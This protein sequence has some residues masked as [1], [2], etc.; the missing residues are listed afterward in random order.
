MNANVAKRVLFVAHVDSHI[1]AFHIPFLKFFKDHSFIV[2]VASNGNTHFEY[3]YHKYNL[4]FQ[5]NPLSLTNYKAFKQLRKILNENKYDIIH[6]HTPT[7]GV[8]ARL[9]NRF[10]KHYTTTQIIYSAHGFHFFNG[11]SAIKNFIFKNIEKYMAKITDVIITV[12]DEDYIAAKNFKL[13]KNGYVTKNP[14]VGI[15]IQKIHEIQ[16]NRKE[17]LY[18]L[19]IPNDSLLLLSVGEIN[20]NKNHKIVIKILSSLPSYCHYIICG[21]G[22]KENELKSLCKEL[23]ISDRVHFLGFRTDIIYIM[24][25]SD[26]F[27]FPSKREGLGLVGIEAM[28]S[29]LPVIGSN[30]RGI[31][32]YSIDGETGFLFNPNDEDK[33][34][35]II[36]DLV[37]NTELRKTIGQS[38]VNRIDKYDINNVICQMEKIYDM[39]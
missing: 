25:S 5:R 9:A 16:G 33:L 39:E 7:G 2:D 6:C 18:S 27:V 26:I 29:G 1:Q 28:A 12:N 24:K 19:S 3:C 10:S 22:E 35:Q 20:D 30:I 34:L 38:N 36:L 13:K 37:K 23:N 32:D 21:K 17:F 31:T 4:P 11:N 14:G 15:D 8:I